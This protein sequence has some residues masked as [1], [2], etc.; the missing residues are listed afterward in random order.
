MKQRLKDLWKEGARLCLVPGSTGELAKV[1]KDV[2][3]IVLIRDFSHDA[4][5]GK[6]LSGLRKFNFQTMDYSNVFFTK[7]HHFSWCYGQN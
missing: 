2:I 6:D 1:R 4:A 7:T 5:A 3:I